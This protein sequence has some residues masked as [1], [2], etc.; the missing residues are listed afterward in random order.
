LTII[1]GVDPVQ[2]VKIG[3][4]LLLKSLNFHAGGVSV[5]EPRNTQ[6]I[7]EKYILL[8]YT[9]KIHNSHHG[10]LN[11]FDHFNKIGFEVAKPPWWLKVNFLNI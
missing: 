6:K 3:P 4:Y 8:V 5:Y 11:E 1:V 7:N 2:M 9:L 10:G